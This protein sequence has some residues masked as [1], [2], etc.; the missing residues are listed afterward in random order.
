[1]LVL[2]TAGAVLRHGVVACLALSTALAHAARPLITDDARIVDAKACQLESWVRRNRG[3]IEYW[4]LPGCNP[5]GNVEL[6]LGGAATHD[7]SSTATTSLVAQAKTI[8]RP[9]GGDG[10]GVGLAG[11]V[12]RHPRSARGGHDRYVYVPMTFAVNRERLFIHTNVGWLREQEER[13]NRMTWGVGG[14]LPFSERDSLIA[15]TFSQ[16]SGKPLVQLGLRHWIVRNRVQID[17]TYGDRVGSG[18]GER[19]F[20]VGLRLL[21]PPFLP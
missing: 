5:T 18:S 21:S 9:L 13:R 8:L 4:A 11:G 20:S 10:W 1:M 2:D 15:E 12:V 14:E 3:S 17:A 16:D 19:W 6:T 7:A